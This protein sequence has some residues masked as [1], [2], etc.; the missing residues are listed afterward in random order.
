MV[1][2]VVRSEA[3]ALAPGAGLRPS[4]ILMVVAVGAMVPPYFEDL[5][6]VT[7]TPP[8]YSGGD[9]IDDLGW[10]AIAVAGCVLAAVIAG[11]IW[12]WIF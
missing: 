6:I 9:G 3:R 1:S 5:L 12:L 4:P 8:I 10:A 11:A 2:D 7:E